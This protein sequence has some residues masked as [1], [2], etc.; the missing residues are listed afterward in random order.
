VVLV[1]RDSPNKPGLEEPGLWV[2]NP[3]PQPGLG[4]AKMLWV[5]V[6]VKSPV[7]FWIAVPNGEDV[8]SRLAKPP[9]RPP[10]AAGR[11]APKSP[12]A[13]QEDRSTRSLR[14]VGLS[15]RPPVLSVDEGVLVENTLLEACK[16][17]V[18]PA[19]RSARCAS[20]NERSLYGTSK[21][22]DWKC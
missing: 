13:G 10:G 7:L 12:P 6:D 3:P 8:L 14:V 4:R 19:F 17:P 2:P 22:T 9:K 5:P 16:G 11:L 1:V 18:L 21:W 15:K 20:S